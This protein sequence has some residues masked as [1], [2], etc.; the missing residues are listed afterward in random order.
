M[1]QPEK[2][3]KSAAPGD[4]DRLEFFPGVWEKE[5]SDKLVEM[6]ATPLSKEEY[7]RKAEEKLAELE[8]ECLYL[9]G[10][11]ELHKPKLSEEDVAPENE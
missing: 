8:T 7:I 6:G 9:K 10:W 4:P 2:S 3:E 11:I 1:N 5:V